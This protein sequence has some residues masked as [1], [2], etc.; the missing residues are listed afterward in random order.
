[1]TPTS[2]C[3]FRTVAVES[4]Q[5]RNYKTAVERSYLIQ[6]FSIVFVL[7]GVWISHVGEAFRAEGRN[8]RKPYFAA[9]RENCITDGEVS[10][11]VNADNISRVR[12]LSPRM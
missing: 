3:V 10:R 6:P 7:A 1:M 11:I 2:G 12:S 4:P 8:A 5:Y 9:A